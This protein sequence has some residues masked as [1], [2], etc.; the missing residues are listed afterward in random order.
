[1]TARK[2]KCLKTV[3]LRLSKVHCHCHKSLW[4]R[5]MMVHLW[6]ILALPTVSFIW[7]LATFIFWTSCT[8]LFS[9][10]TISPCSLARRIALI[11]WPKIQFTIKS[12]LGGQK[13]FYYPYHGQIVLLPFY[14]YSTAILE[15]LPIFFIR[16]TLK[17]RFN[18]WLSIACW[19]LFHPLVR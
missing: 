19:H 13:G 3:F 11:Y 6:L 2:P 17:R 10:I 14:I 1:M 5:L 18:F 4:G 9:K 12:D 15:I 8:H 7:N 16:R